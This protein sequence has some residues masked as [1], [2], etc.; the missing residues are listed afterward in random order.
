MSL[1]LLLALFLLYVQESW[2]PGWIP[3]PIEASLS[4][5]VGGQ[6][7][8]AL[9]AT[10]V[11][12]RRRRALANHPLERA[13]TFRSHGRDRT[14]HAV[15]AMGLFLLSLYGFGWGWAVAQTLPEWASPLTKPVLMTPLLFGLVTAWSAHYGFERAAHATVWQPDERLFPTRG[16][17]LATLARHHFLLAAPPL[18]LM[19]LQEAVI[20][21][22][23][24]V[25][26]FDASPALA[27]GLLAGLVVFSLLLMPLILRLFLG[28]RP[29][30][31]GPLR[32]RLT[33]TLKA[34]GFRIGDLLHW[35]TGGAQANA[36]VSGV[37]PMFR[38]VVFTDRLLAHLE[39]DEIEAVLGHELG[40]VRHRHLAFYTFFL[41]ASIWL[42][43]RGFRALAGWADANWSLPLPQEALL[44]VAV[45]YVFVVFGFFSRRCE[46]QADLYGCRFATRDAFV[47]ALEKV[48]ILNGVP[49]ER[50]GLL[51][52]W[53]HGTIASR[54]AFLESLDDA[55]R[56]ERRFQR[57]LGLAKWAV[58][59]A[60]A[61]GA[62]P[63]LQEA[64]WNWL[65]VK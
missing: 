58:T 46:R 26:D 45:A 9:V 35:D 18:I 13:A 28:L 39:P 16:A 43:E 48:A 52:M 32:E 40:H 7:L 14:V 60:L 15:A 5:G 44:V 64:G 55:G 59:L 56:R 36:M 62:L 6:A 10:L 31:A 1:F 23:P 21:F 50:P 8:L 37:F 41:L 11:A 17:Y 54:V 61:A 47:R 57:Q 3:L 12:W 30:P 22:A 27:L 19:T 38:Y 20:A 24:S 42:I 4:V 25:G 29:L 33:A 63:L 49:R 65:A 53:Q 51:A 34:R 2:S